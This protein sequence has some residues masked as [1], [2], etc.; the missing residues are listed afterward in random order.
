MLL[1]ILS[2]AELSLE[3]LV[4]LR[5]HL[6]EL[7]PLYYPLTCSEQRIVFLLVMM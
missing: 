5:V 3:N 1:S 6:P 2:V 7:H 4:L